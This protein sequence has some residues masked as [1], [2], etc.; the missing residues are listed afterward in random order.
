MRTAKNLQL[1]SILGK[2]K[3]VSDESAAAEEIKVL[4][5]ENE[6][7]KTELEACKGELLQRE[8]Q[9]KECAAELEVC[10]NTLLSEQAEKEKLATMVHDLTRTLIEKICKNL[11]QLA[12]LV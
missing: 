3:Q 6:R 10:K 9:Q 8:Q 11:R 4:K 7:L 12:M 2:R 5:M 1:K